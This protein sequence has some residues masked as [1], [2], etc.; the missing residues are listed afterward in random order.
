[1]KTAA[2]I[3][4]HHLKR[5]TRSPGLILLLMAIP[6]TLAGIEYA[7]FA[8]A[9]A[10]G[11]L[12]PIKVLVLDEDRTFASSAVPR[13]IGSGPLTDYIELDTTPDV[14]SARRSLQRGQASALILVPKGFQQ[15]L[16]DRKT[17][18]IRFVPNPAQTISPEIVRS[19]LEMLTAI[20]NGLLARAQ[21]PLD[22]INNVAAA[23]RAPTEDEVAEISRGFFRAGQQLQIL[24][25][26]Q[27]LTVDVKRPS[28]TTEQFQ[29]TGGARSFFAYIFPGL[30]MF[31]LMFISQ[32]LATRLMRDREA[33]L[34]R[35]IAVAPT[36]R[37][38]ILAGGAFYLFVALMVVLLLLALIGS[39]VFRLPLTKP[40][41]LLVIA[42]GF[43]FFAT[44][45]QLLVIAMARSDAGA[46]AVAGAIIMILS[47][48]G[49]AFVPLE[50]Y[51]PVLRAI[52]ELLPNGAA[53]QAFIDVLVRQR[54][55]W[56][57]VRPV[58]IVWAW[59]LAFTA[60]A[61]TLERRRL[62]T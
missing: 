30:V 39:L 52:G 24:N 29:F 40:G 11:K 49:G 10:S 51:P 55:L 6:L 53:H 61:V 38:A 3:A 19:M 4:A 58:A 62:T 16:F 21:A 14:P 50:S 36:S 45:L 22:A 33:G 26:L 20:T 28:G 35:R 54:T 37:A 32:A 25:E 46:Q 13:L 59:A 57:I 34:Q 60:V 18:E 56:E 47:L 9:A 7:A 15:A 23:G 8:P 1:M 44:G 48:L 5:I 17:A 41:T 12:P 42:F 27:N 2:I 31:G 43:A